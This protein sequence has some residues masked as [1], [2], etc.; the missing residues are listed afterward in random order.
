MKAHES[1]GPAG[2]GPAAAERAPVRVPGG[3]P[4]R[5]AGLPGPSVVVGLQRAAGNLAVAGMLEPTVQR[6]PPV[7]MGPSPGPIPSKPGG[8]GIGDLL[9]GTKKFKVRV[10]SYNLH[11]ASAGQRFVWSAEKGS[12]KG[13]DVPLALGVIP[14]PMPV[15]PVA[16]ELSAGVSAYAGGNAL[17]DLSVADV[18]LEATAADLLKVGVAAAALL[19][20]GMPLV[21]LALL[22]SLN[23]PG[24]ATLTATASATV[25]AGA[26][27]YI[28]GLANPTVWPVAGYVKGSLGAEG[29]VKAKA[30][31]TG[32]VKVEFSLGKLRVIGASFRAGTAL[33][34]ELALRAA[35]AAGMM[36]GY[37]PAAIERE[38]WRHDAKA[39]LGIDV[40]SG[41]KGGDFATLTT[42]DDGTPV[43]D[44]EQVLVDGRALVEA[45]FST[46]NAANDH[47]DPAPPGD[48][49]GVSAQGIGRIGMHG[50]GKPS[51]LRN[52]PQILWLQS[53][54]VIPYATG[55][56][57]WQM[58]NLAMP[59]RGGH[60]DR[61]QTTIMIYYGAALRKNPDDNRM[62]RNFAAGVTRE[63]VER[64]LT[65]ARLANDAGHP[66]ALRREG[67]ELLGKL[68]QGLRVAMADA[69]TRTNAAV[70]AENSSY[71]DGNPLTNGQRRAAPG[72]SEPPL[73][74]PGDIAQAANTQY[75][76]VVDLVQQAVD[77][78]N[79][80]RDP[81]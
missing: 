46:R 3:Q 44:L 13:T 33:K 62:S 78:M 51:S 29:S 77:S 81:P 42:G 21:S 55:Q 12:G 7:P 43:I 24:E 52:G 74:P 16:M 36:L 45:L 20:P 15:G 5:T 59:G 17:L 31:F 40:R 41:V 65:S 6:G 1:S 2:A 67:P 57:L 68:M 79:A 47:V 66:E 63:E 8:W 25:E 27:A 56:R 54:H 10:G 37:R 71:T 34:A 35:I 80:L 4:P 28:K 61:G 70:T 11:S 50:S 72:T 23:L 60:E 18:I 58:V 64:R 38:L 53:E 22:A 76:N 69:V 14:L 9:D 75:D 32:P 19:V 49:P 73:P 39:G 30:D 26:D 48:N